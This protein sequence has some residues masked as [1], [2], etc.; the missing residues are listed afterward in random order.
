M[1]L[2]ELEVV[3]RSC[4]CT[5]CLVVPSAVVV[6]VAVI[7]VIGTFDIRCWQYHYTD[8]PLT[9]DFVV[10]QLP[11]V[12]NKDTVVVVYDEITTS[13]AEVDVVITVSPS[14]ISLMA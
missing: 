6:V 1:N 13:S 12:V 3:A 5:S 2:L 14:Q 8:I 7:K 4:C 11:L 10:S 9:V